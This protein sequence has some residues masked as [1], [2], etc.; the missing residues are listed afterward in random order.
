[1]NNLYEYLEFKELSA[2]AKINAINNVREERYSD[3]IASWV[4]DDSSLLEPP[5]SEM[6][7]LFGV[8]YYKANRNRFM[9]ENNS[10]ERISFVG[11]DDPNYYF[12]CKE[13]IDVTND[14]LFRRWLGIPS[15]FH[16]YFYYSFEE[17]RSS[18]T[19]IDFRLDA[20]DEFNEKF[21]KRVQDILLDFFKKAQE[22]FD[23]H[24]DNVLTQ[25]TSSINDEFEDE[26]II[27]FI[28]NNEYTFEEDG[29]PF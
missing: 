3:N 5:E 19:T 10:P 1:M 4:V 8:D 28:E 26:S 17:S 15:R 14:N 24:I 11:K 23:S 20:E 18:N 29:S 6:T 27:E 9:I 13:S 22:K 25:V 2:D 12:H 16:R 21:D 7:A